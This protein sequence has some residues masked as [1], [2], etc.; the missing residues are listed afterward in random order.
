MQPPTAGIKRFVFPMALIIPL[1]TALVIGRSDLIRVE[2]IERENFLYQG[3]NRMAYRQ[4][5]KDLQHR[6]GRF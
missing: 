1:N 4:Y 5:G 3:A 2:Q 6:D